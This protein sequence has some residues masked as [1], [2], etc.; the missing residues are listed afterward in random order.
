MLHAKTP[1]SA[2]N[3]RRLCELCKTLSRPRRD[4]IKPDTTNFRVSIAFYF[5]LIFLEA[6][7]FHYLKIQDSLPPPWRGRISEYFGLGK[8]GR[9]FAT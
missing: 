8:W 3:T 2:K 5:R 1:R 4:E 7:R 6:L 9:S